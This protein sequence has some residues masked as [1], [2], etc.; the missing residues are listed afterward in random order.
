MYDPD[1]FRRELESNDGEAGISLIG[2][3]GSGTLYDLFGGWTSP[4]AWGGG[5]WRRVESTPELLQFLPY[6]RISSRYRRWDCMP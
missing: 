1:Q 4:E 2:I 6:V 3:P 5:Y